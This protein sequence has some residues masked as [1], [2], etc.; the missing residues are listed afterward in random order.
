[1]VLTA[2]NGAAKSNSLILKHLI[3]NNVKKFQKINIFDYYTNHHN[4]QSAYQISNNVPDKSIFNFEELNHKSFLLDKIKESSYLVY[5]THGYFVN[6][7]CKNELLK[8]V[9]ELCMNA[10]LKQVVFV[11]NLELA[12]TIEG[13]R[14][15]EESMENE[16][17]I[18]ENVP[19]SRVLWHYPTYGSFVDFISSLK[20]YPGNEC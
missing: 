10:N 6:T 17:W 18:L 5:F 7:T 8:I 4:Y 2:I 15:L 16:K 19:R 1:M 3:T 12:H 13:E 20:K 9:G 14:Y 11:N